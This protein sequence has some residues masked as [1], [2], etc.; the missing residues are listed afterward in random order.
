M[1]IRRRRFHTVSAKT[2]NQRTNVQI[3]FLFHAAAAARALAS[4]AREGATTR[5]GN[6]LA[7]AM[8][9]LA[10]GRHLGELCRAIPLLHQRCAMHT[11]IQQ[12]FRAGAAQAAVMTLQS[13]GSGLALCRRDRGRRGR[14]IA[15]ATRKGMGRVENACKTRQLRSGKGRGMIGIGGKD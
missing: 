6:L 5:R 2:P 12:V 10:V 3:S 7:N 8:R 1:N 13:L 14:V 9:N 4:H 15:P 11:T